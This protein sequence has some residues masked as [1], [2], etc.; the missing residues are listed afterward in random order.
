MGLYIELLPIVYCA[1][2]PADYFAHYSICVYYPSL[3]AVSQ[4][5]PRSE[6]A[7][8]SGAHANGTGL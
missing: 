3:H 1:A 8:S 4:P 5:L 6:A 7:H 2:E